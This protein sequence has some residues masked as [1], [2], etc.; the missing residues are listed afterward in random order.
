MQPT[1][2]AVMTRDPVTAE[3]GTPFKKLTELLDQHRISAM[4]GEKNDQYQRNLARAAA[5]V[6]TT[7]VSVLKTDRAVP[8]GSAR[9]VQ[10]IF[11]YPGSSKARKATGGNARK[12]TLA[13]QGRVTA[14]TTISRSG[15]S[16]STPQPRDWTSASSPRGRCRPSG[17]LRRISSRPLMT[18]RARG[19]W[20]RSICR[21]AASVV[22]AGAT[23]RTWWRARTS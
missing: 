19:D 3:T 8:S 4:P 17:V 22:A 14:P 15:I 5:S 21:A 13:S 23:T 10:A 11:T 2:A 6:E 20:S 18:A 9:S 16:A 1:V 12:T 7:R